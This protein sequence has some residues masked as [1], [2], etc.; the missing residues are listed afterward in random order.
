MNEG[1]VIRSKSGTT[2]WESDRG[3][4]ILFG[5][6]GIPSGVT[7]LMDRLALDS[8]DLLRFLH[9]KLYEHARA[10][11]RAGNA[12][13]RFWN[14]TIGADP[15]YIELNHG[16]LAQVLG[17]MGTEMPDGIAANASFELRHDIAR[18]AYDALR[19]ELE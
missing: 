16:Q 2:F 3:Q 19:K 9:I 11:G 17:L 4:K 14:R 1:P 15:T 12:L 13:G 5:L 18:V 7:S 8:H 10:Q 6:T